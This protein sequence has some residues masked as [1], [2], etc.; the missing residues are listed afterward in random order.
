[1]VDLGKFFGRAANAQPPAQPQEDAALAADAQPER[2][3]PV[4]LQL[5]S[6]TEIPAGMAMPNE[7]PCL[8]EFEQLLAQQD[9]LHA[10][11][12][13]ARKHGTAEAVARMRAQIARLGITASDLGFVLPTQAKPGTANTSK[14]KAAPKYRD[15]V[16]GRTWTGWGRSPEWIK[17]KD[18]QQFLMPA[19][20]NQEI[21]QPG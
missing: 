15:P 12:E 7:T 6:L 3:Q 2:E 9:A 5:D 1:M 17:G 19:M 13:A 18:R 4:F 14:G 10:R 20:G 21:V 8:A 16:T 11:V